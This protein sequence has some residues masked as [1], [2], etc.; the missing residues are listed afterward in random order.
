VDTAHADSVTAG[1]MVNGIIV[2]NATSAGVNPSGTYLA[3]NN[4]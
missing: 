1:N 3:D 2:G 4:L